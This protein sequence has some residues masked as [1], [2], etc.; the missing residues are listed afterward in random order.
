MKYKITGI[1]KDGDVVKFTVVYNTKTYNF[2]IAVED[3]L[4]EPRWKIMI[5]DMILLEEI[6]KQVTDSQIQTLATKYE[7]KDVAV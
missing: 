3:A 4:N 6:R 2:N 7:N 5:R 1:Q